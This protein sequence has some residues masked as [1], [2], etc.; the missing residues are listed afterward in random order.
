MNKSSNLAGRS[1]DDAEAVSVQTQNH[2]RQLY[3][4]IAGA[5]RSIDNHRSLNLLVCSASH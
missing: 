3:V 1:F 5:L 2:H 4:T